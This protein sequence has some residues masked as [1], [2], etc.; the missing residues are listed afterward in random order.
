[1]NQIKE[2]KKY[3]LQYFLSDY[4]KIASD[5]TPRG[6][7]TKIN[8]VPEKY[9]RIGINLTDLKVIMD[10]KNSYGL[11][12]KLRDN[13]RV[14]FIKDPF[15]EDAPDLRGIKGVYA[16]IFINNHSSFAP[17]LIESLPN[18]R[19]I[20]MTKSDLT[21]YFGIQTAEEKRQL[22]KERRKH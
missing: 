16:E 21:K 15:L 22:R 9:T 3:N 11:N 12:F 17:N 18:G 14:F 10:E 19:V 7:M 20:V 5:N 2:P 8:E 13:S 1:M 6:N 4:K